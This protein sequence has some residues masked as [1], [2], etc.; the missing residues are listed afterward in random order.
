MHLDHSFSC[1]SGRGEGVGVG[2][3]ILL[4]DLDRAAGSGVKLHGHCLCEVAGRLFQCLE[5]RECDSHGVQKQ[6]HRLE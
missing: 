6:S 2:F 5:I 1:E 3:R 4:G